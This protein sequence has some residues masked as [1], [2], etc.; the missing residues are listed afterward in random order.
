MEPLCPNDGWSHLE[1]LQILENDNIM[2]LRVNFDHADLV[3]KF[4]VICF[5]QEGGQPHSCHGALTTPSP[6][7]LAAAVFTGAGDL[8]R[9]LRPCEVYC[10]SLHDSLVTAYL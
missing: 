10:D 7:N 2:T 1:P 5:S 4:S 9:I 8:V 6:G 3:K